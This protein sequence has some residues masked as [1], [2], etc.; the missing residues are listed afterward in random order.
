MTT[1]TSTELQTILVNHAKWV[2]GDPASGADLNG[3]DL[4]HA[5]LSRA[6][7][8]YANLR[9]E[10]VKAVSDYCREVRDGVFPG[11]EHSFTSQA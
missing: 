7:L 9:G 6:I 5:K 2:D 11:P 8:S 3:A 1:L 10:A 4:S